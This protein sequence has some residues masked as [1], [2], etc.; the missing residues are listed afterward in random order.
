MA[1]PNYTISIREP[2]VHHFHWGIRVEANVTRAPIHNCHFLISKLMRVAKDLNWDPFH[3]GGS[4]DWEQ[5]CPGYH[6]I[7]FHRLGGNGNHRHEV[8]QFIE[9][10][11]AG[12]VMPE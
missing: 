2:D 12:F 7:E 9:G 8:Q 4:H 11:Q 10:F 5:K 6:Y 3:Q 1:R